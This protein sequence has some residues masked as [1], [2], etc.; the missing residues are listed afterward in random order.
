MGATQARQLPPSGAEETAWSPYAASRSSPSEE[1]AWG[2]R[3]VFGDGSSHVVL[4]AVFVA[5]MG[6]GAASAKVFVGRGLGTMA[7]PRAPMRSC[8]EKIVLN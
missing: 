7:A 5:L 1:M 2:I 6:G 8:C 4:V 3:I